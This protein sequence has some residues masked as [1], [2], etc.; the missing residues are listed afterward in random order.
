MIGS[1]DLDT[2]RLVFIFQNSTIEMLY[3]DTTTPNRVARR[4][5]SQCVRRITLATQKPIEGYTAYYSADKMSQ[6]VFPTL[7][8]GITLIFNQPSKRLTDDLFR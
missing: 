1:C 5:K 8:E 3:I 6:K 4:P 2:H 7:V